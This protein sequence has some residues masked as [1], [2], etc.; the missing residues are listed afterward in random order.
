MQSGRH[1][2]LAG[3][4]GVIGGPL[5][6]TKPDMADTLGPIVF[7][8]VVVGGMGSLMGAFYA[9]LLIGLTQTF[10]VAFNLSFGAMLSAIGLDVDPSGEIARITLSSLAPLT[11]YILLILFMIFRPRGLKGELEL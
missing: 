4:A 7:V 1:K 8:V 2:R 3:L 5:L 11:P 9:S 6:N 10:F